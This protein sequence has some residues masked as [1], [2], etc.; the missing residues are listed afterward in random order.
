MPTQVNLGTVRGTDG[1]IN[2]VNNLMITG[3]DGIEVSQLSDE[4]Q[5]S[6]PI[7]TNH[8]GNTNN[9][10][11]VTKAQLGLS[12]VDNKSEAT[13]LNDAKTN[14][15]TSANIS[16]ALGYTPVSP[17]QA[18]GKQAKLTGTVGQMVTFDSNGNAIVTDDLLNKPIY[19]FEIIKNE[20]NP[21]SKIRYIDA[22]RNYASAYMNFNTLQF[23]YGDWKGA[24]II[25]DIKPRIMGFDGTIIEE[26]DPNDY[27][28]KTDG[29]ASS[30]YN[31]I[32]N[33]NVMV[34]FPTMWLKIEDTT[35]SIRVHIA[36]YKADNDYHAWAHTDANG[37]IV[38]YAYIAAYNG[39]DHYIGGGPN[40]KIRS[41]SGKN[42]YQMDLGKI[43]NKIAMCRANNPSGATM[44]DMHTFAER[45]LLTILILL[46]GKSTDVQETFG[47]GHSCLVNDGFPT[48]ADI[49]SIIPGYPADG[50][51]ADH[52][53]MPTGTMDTCG[54]FWGCKDVE[55]PTA[56]G[57]KNSMGVKVF[58][59]EH[60][61]GNLYDPLQGFISVDK[62]IKVKLTRGTH[63]GSTVSD[64][65]TTGEG[66]IEIG[67]MEGGRETISSDY[68]FY[69]GYASQLVGNQYGLFVSNISD[70]SSSTYYCDRCRIM[71]KPDQSSIPVTTFGIVNG[72][73]MQTAY[74]QMGKNGIFHW[75]LDNPL[76]NGDGLIGWT[77]VPR[78]SL[79]V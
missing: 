75:S 49:H 34:G 61:W 55:H 60:L 7:Y 25:T 43:S 67:N 29:S 18:A 51:G 58:G 17:T 22:N 26:L 13:I 56:I 40:H 47:M 74:Q 66:Y 24:W 48:A 6:A 50:L 77:M 46:I 10:H 3:S 15:M 63:D 2:G 4:M 30:I 11:N 1:T 45:E 38:D 54:L 79:K 68:K 16:T 28:K 23:N 41:I 31:P 20:S 73:A 37:N 14:I 78:L 39:W 69:E 57:L 70:G 65:N 8:A 27:T 33:G 12:N 76:A 21:A 72:Y 53:A 52:S 32:V 59:I 71:V 44:W 5:I 62:L 35:D 9:P 36:P 42:I 64:Y 19:G